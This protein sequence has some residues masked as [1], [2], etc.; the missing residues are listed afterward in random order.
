MNPSSTVCY[1]TA[2]HFH[3]NQ[4]Q[5]TAFTQLRNE[6]SETAFVLF[7]TSSKDERE[8]FLIALTRGWL[9][10]RCL[11]DNPRAGDLTP[12]SATKN[13]DLR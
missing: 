4:K 8:Y 10:G 9:I 1:S 13:E 5:Q 12:R 6:F 7:F 2:L 3:V 11:T